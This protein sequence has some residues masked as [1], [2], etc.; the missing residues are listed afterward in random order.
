M[1]PALRPG[2]RSEF[3]V[4]AEMI[5]TAGLDY[6]TTESNLT[7]RESGSDEYW[8]SKNHALLVKSKFRRKT[9]THSGKECYHYNEKV[10]C[11]RAFL[12]LVVKITRV[13]DRLHH[14]SGNQTIP[15]LMMIW[16]W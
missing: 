4:I 9:N 7:N 3:S 10:C 15:V 6:I 8:S 2:C 12:T 5:R 14:M 1:K 13:A 16:H 11:S